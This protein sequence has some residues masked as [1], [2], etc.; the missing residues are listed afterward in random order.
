MESEVHVPRMALAVQGPARRQR[1][2]H[3]A[4]T[5]DVDECT[6]R[7]PRRQGRGRRLPQP[8]REGRVQEHQ[9]EGLGR[10]LEIAQRPGQ[11]CVELFHHLLLQAQQGQAGFA[12]NDDIKRLQPADI[13]ILVRDRNEAALV[14][15]ELSARNVRSVYLSD[16]DSIFQSAEASAVLTWLRACQQP[17]DENLLRTALALPLSGNSDAQLQLWLNDEQAW[18]QLTE[19]VRQFR[20][21]WLPRQS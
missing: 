8:G 15:R 2:R 1:R 6:G 21:I 13:A 18:E 5:F 14:R 7:Q 12:S 20:Q 11:H 19:Q 4:G 16:N 9:I 3:V 10:A 17:E